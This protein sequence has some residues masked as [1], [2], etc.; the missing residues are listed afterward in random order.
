M[1]SNAFGGNDALTGGVLFP[2]RFVVLSENDLY[3][4][5]Y[6]MF[7]NSRG[8][9]DTMI[10]GDGLT[11]GDGSNNFLYGD[12]YTMSNDASGG[13]DTLTGGVHDSTD[14]VGGAEKTNDDHH[15]GDNTDRRGNK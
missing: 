6:A 7:D 10:G 12:A 15:G 3:G 2:T 13:E 5:A 1:S 11:V 9:D 14:L 8:G 4:D